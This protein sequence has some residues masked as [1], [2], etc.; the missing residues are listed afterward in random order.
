MPTP[1]ESGS[2]HERPPLEPIHVLR[3]RRTDALAELFREMEQ[4]RDD[5]ETVA[6]QDPRSWD[7]GETQEIPRVP[8]DE[9]GASRGGTPGSG[10]G[11]R[12][13]AVVIAV[14]AAALVGF[15]C[16]LLLSMRNDHA[17]AQEP[18]PT[19]SAETTASPTATVA[20][21]ADPDGPGTLRE[22]DSGPEVTDLQQRLL[23]VPDIYPGGSTSGTFDATLKAAVARFQLWYGIRGDE[24]GV[25]GDDT[26]R[27]LE[28]RTSY[29]TG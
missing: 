13:A 18:R 9:D 10:S 21:A 24:T 20:G 28:S 11:L 2:P 26:R 15:G 3:P 6:V 25:Y 27:A 4:G 7:E 22:G 12:R 16:A 19:A 14:A 5:M 23:N 17:A 29:D 8:S 1:P